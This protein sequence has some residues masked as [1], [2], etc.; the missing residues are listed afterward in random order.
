[1]NLK[2]YLHGLDIQ[3]REKLAEAC[4]STLGHLRNVMYGYRPCSAELAAAIERHTER[5][6]TRK[7]M[8]PDDWIEV[9]PELADLEEKEPLPSAERSCAAT[10][11]A[12]VQGV[13]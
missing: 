4:G 10:E 2:Q 13:E 12:T 11:S 1:M 7:D 5:A 3:E 6:V 8:R 9:W